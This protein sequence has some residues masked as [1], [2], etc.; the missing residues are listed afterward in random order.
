M[1][2]RVADWLDDA[3]A[4]SSIPRLSIGEKRYGTLGKLCTVHTAHS[5]Q[6]IEVIG[7]YLEEF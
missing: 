7:T 6:Y 2:V 5:A 4:S 1:A 3:I